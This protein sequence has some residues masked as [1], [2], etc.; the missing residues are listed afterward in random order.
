MVRP[1]RR[2]LN[3][4][5]GVRAVTVA[6][7]LVAA[8]LVAAGLAGCDRPM[9]GSA[10]PAAW[11]DRALGGVSLTQTPNVVSEPAARDV[12]G[13]L[14]DAEDFWR[15]LLVGHRT[16]VTGGYTLIDTAA[17]APAGEPAICAGAG[18]VLSGN[19]LYCP[20]Q[21]RIVL[22][23]AALVPVLRDSYGVGGLA[24]SLAHE[25]GHAVQARIR[26][27]AEQPDSRSPQLLLEAQADC[28][29]G[30][31]LQW[32]VDGH[33]RRLHLPAGA[34][35]ESVAPLLD[36]RDAPTAPGDAASGTARPIHG[37]SLDRLRFVLRGMRDGPAACWGM[38][39]AGLRL[40]LSRA[41]TGPEGSHRF[42]D[43]AAVSAAAQTSVGSFDRSAPVRV[44]DPRDTAA[45]A[46]YGQFAQA[47][48]TALATG[49]GRYPNRAGAA[50]FTGAWTSAVFGTA[51]AGQLGSWPGDAD[52]ALDLVRNRPGTTWAEMAA[53]ADGFDRGLSACR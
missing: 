52:E 42:A 45:A 12:A 24:A 34:L 32:V 26:P 21:D 4:R 3:R 20:S 38:T 18:E 35:P 17:T 10:A 28:A 7:A 23:A 44:A 16:P 40:T 13:I 29:A 8:A 53:F 37:L 30:A 49:R 47:A 39:A 6:A 19:A 25:F 50:C 51:G 22:D 15:P 9:A 41:G 14:A 36:F 11:V 46:P 5:P 27:P 48:A 43:L 1:G 31:F 2:G 33:S